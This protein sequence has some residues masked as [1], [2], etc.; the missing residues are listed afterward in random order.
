MRK[1]V[2]ILT[3]LVLMAA[4]FQS[5]CM[6]AFAITESEVEAQVASSGKAAVTG[7]VLIWFLCAV[8]FLKVSQKIDSFMAT[9]GVNVGRTGGSL[10]SEAMIAM[11]AITMVL[12]GKGGG[13]KA[14][15]GG[16]GGR[17]A[18]A[19]MAGFF[20]GGLIGMTGRHIT[21]SAVRTATAQT[22]AVH[23]AQERAENT[24]S[25]DQASSFDNASPFDQP[26]PASPGE[27]PHA[28]IISTGAVTTTGFDSPLNSPSG[29]AEAVDAQ[30][31]PQAGVILTGSEPTASADGAV[32]LSES[33][34]STIESAPLEGG[35]PQE[36]GGTDVPGGPIVDAPPLD[37]SVSFINV[38]AAKAEESEQ[39]TQGGNG[40][41]QFSQAAPT[42]KITQTNQSFTREVS[43]PSLGGAIFHRSL[44]T[45]GSFANNVIGTVARGEVAGSITGDMAVQSMVSY[46]GYAGKGI[47]SGG[48]PSYSNV[49]IGGGRISGIE[50]SPGASSGREFAMYHA[51][52]YTVPTGE[53]TKVTSAD[54]ALWY[55]QYAQDAVERK[56]YKAPD[57][58][59]AYHENIVKRLP[60][61]PRRKDRL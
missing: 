8:A 50:T 40:Q 24:V 38:D 34:G 35:T 25:F 49:E 42:N 10:L 37:G 9:L 4:L 57:D 54:G 23:T 7:N 20:K 61:P 52:R 29:K 44:V 22:S 33:G 1:T 16:G 48:A 3:V 51:D 28:G 36:A 17:S 32:H 14:S 41:A 11:R 46:M 58:T 18:S 47:V 45:G 39:T 56:P 60:D 26:S 21:N 5:L 2:R 31:P 55:K 15:A 59:V 6:P 27:S 13:V 53:Y 30:S 43:R 12:G 19:G